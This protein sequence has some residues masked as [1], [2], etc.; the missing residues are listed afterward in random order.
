[1]SV[2]D[3]VSAVVEEHGAAVDAAARSLVTSGADAFTRD[4]FGA[5]IASLQAGDERPTAAIVSDAFVRTSDAVRP[6]LPPAR[7]EHAMRLL[8]QTGA[9]PPAWLVEA[10]TDLRPAEADAG[11]AEPGPDPRAA[12]T[13]P[14]DTAWL[15]AELAAA[16]AAAAAEA[17]AQ[18]WA[19]AAAEP[20][21]VAE[22]APGRGRRRLRSG[23]LLAAAAV[24]LLLAAGAYALTRDDP[25]PPAPVPGS[26]TTPA[27]KAPTQTA[28]ERR[29]ERR[30]A[31]AERRR[32]AAQ[33]RD[34]VKAHRRD[35]V[36]SFTASVRQ[37]AAPAAPAATAAPTASAPSAAEPP[38][39]APAPAPTSAPRPAPTAPPPRE[40]PPGREAP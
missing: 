7:R 19:P 2:T 21:A 34:A 22:F 1:M 26:A 5:V 25:A 35:A 17:P 38:P 39:S 11:T 27:A 40:D 28:A 15:P 9:P 14:V 31:R 37:P 36:Q 32:A 24:L 33:R 29:A 10:V 23:P 4:V 13:A 30:R 3:E 20:A 18:E 16:P 8:E 12:T 6:A